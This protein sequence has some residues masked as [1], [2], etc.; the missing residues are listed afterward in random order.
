M[1]ATKHVVSLPVTFSDAGSTPA[2]S[3]TITH[4]ITIKLL[5][6]FCTAEAAEGV[7]L[8]IVRLH[9]PHC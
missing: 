3:T 5:Y 2:A 4:F 1:N 6:R 8:G 7:R 9:P